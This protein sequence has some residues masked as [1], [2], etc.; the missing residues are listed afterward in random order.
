[1]IDW[2]FLLTFIVAFSIYELI[3]FIFLY[4]LEQIYIRTNWLDWL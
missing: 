1:M 3:K 2:N 4:T